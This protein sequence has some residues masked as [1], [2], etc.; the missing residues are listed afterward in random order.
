ML[1]SCVYT[2]T[3]KQDIDKV[4]QYVKDPFESEYQLLIKRKENVGIK[5]LKNAK[6]F[7][8]HSQTIDNVYEILEDYNP[9]KKEKVITALDGM[10]VDMKAN[11]K[12]S[13]IV[14]ELFLKGRNLNISLVF[15]SQFYFKVHKT[16]CLNATQYF[17]LKI[18]NK[19]EL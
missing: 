3:Q 19:R 5:E 8:N 6:A 11:K 13:I 16:I 2:N 1:F 7:I 4:Y 10:I 9:T 15:I 14:T 17:I 18:P 12:I